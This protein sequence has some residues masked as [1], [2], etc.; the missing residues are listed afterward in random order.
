M[1]RYIT[2]TLWSYIVEEWRGYDRL[3]Q[4]VAGIALVSLPLILVWLVRD[5]P[6]PS[7]VDMLL[8]MFA[9]VSFGYL[10]SLVEITC[11]TFFLS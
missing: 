5:V 8:S 1:V 10:E 6:S 3:Q 11:H 9:L 4:I 2:E 7:V